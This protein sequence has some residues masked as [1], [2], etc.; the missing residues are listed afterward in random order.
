MMEVGW[1]LARTSS[2]ARCRRRR[3]GGEGERQGGDG[4]TKT[5]KDEGGGG[6]Q[7]RGVAVVCGEG[8]GVM[9]PRVP[10]EQMSGGRSG[11]AANDDPLA[12]SVT[13]RGEEVQRPGQAR[14]RPKRRPGRSVAAGGRG[15]Q[16][17]C[18]GAGQGGR[19]ARAE[20]PERS[21]SQGG[22]GG[23][24]AGTSGGSSSRRRHS[25]SRAQLPRS[26]AP[27]RHSASRP[28]GRRGWGQTADRRGE[29]GVRRPPP[30]APP[31]ATPWPSQA[32][33]TRRHAQTGRAVTRAH[34]HPQRHPSHTVVCPGG[35]GAADPLPTQRLPATRAQRERRASLG[36]VATQLSGHGANRSRGQDACRSA[37]ATGRVETDGWLPVAQPSS[38]AA[39]PCLRLQLCF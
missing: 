27:L 28:A 30:A 5:G 37:R 15:G 13:R 14:T 34:T 29:P 9:K 36:S 23:L 31:A 8:D 12:T 6:A 11:S 33:R 21:A 32:D 1:I 18:V 17:C 39:P 3:E 2:L 7:K 25:V 10:Q 16:G 4:V 19:G 35:S 26:D 24:R 20:Q 22:G 38:R